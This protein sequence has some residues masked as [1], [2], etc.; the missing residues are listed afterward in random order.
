MRW[1]SAEVISGQLRA[2]CGCGQ[3]SGVVISAAASKDG[4]T[5]GPTKQSIY[6]LIF[7]L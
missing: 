7:N 3:F 5:D 2:G 6:S 1:L 4:R